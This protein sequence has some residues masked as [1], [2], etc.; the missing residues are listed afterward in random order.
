MYHRFSGPFQSTQD[1]CGQVDFHACL[2]QASVY[3]VSNCRREV[4]D[5]STPNIGETVVSYQTM[6]YKF[7]YTPLVKF[8]NFIVWYDTMK[9]STLERQYDFPLQPPRACI[10]I[11]TVKSNIHIAA[12]LGRSMSS[13]AD[14]CGGEFVGW[15]STASGNVQHCPGTLVYT[16]KNQRHQSDRLFSLSLKVLPTVC[17]RTSNFG[18]ALL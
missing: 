11:P 16:K 2:R 4:G 3:L 10:N 5:V 17:D 8:L 13:V 1:L 18:Q 14:G 7:N 9:T 15:A 6:K 12:I